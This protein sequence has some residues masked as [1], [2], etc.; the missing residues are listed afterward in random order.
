MR[1]VFLLSRELLRDLVRGE[2]LLE[3]DLPLLPLDLDL[4]VLPLVLDLDLVVLP[5]FFDR[6]LVLLKDL[7]RDLVFRPRDLLLVLLLLAGLLERLP[8]RFLLLD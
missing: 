8:V 1:P 4:V 2:R 6:D 5:L 7:D 3:R